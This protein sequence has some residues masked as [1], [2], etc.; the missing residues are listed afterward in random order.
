MAK[1]AKKKLSSKEKEELSRLKDYIEDL[2]FS[3]ESRDPMYQLFLEKMYE[4]KKLPLDQLLSEKELKEQEAIAEKIV[5]KLVKNE[6]TDD[7]SA[8]AKELDIRTKGSR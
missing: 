4:T 2:G 3:F 6:K 5:R 7:L 1:R 8:I